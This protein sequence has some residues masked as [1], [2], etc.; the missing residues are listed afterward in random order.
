MDATI[1]SKSLVDYEFKQ[2]TGFDKRLSKELYKRE[3]KKKMTNLTVSIL[4]DSVVN[5]LRRMRAHE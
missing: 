1:D 4:P 2:R 3:L 5:V